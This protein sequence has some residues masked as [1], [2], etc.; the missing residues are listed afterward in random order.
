MDEPTL[1]ERLRQIK[2]RQYLILILLIIPYLFVIADYI[3]YAVAGVLYTLL[4]IIG[5][6]IIVVY[7]RRNR[8]AAGQ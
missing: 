5:F 3:G 7:Q 1:Q 8:T 4:G 6:G 2:H